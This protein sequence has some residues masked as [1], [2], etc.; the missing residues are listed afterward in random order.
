MIIQP[1][2]GGQQ[3]NKGAARQALRAGLL[4]GL[5]VL[6]PPRASAQATFSE[7]RPVETPPLHD[8]AIA[9]L[10]GDDDPD[11]VAI[12]AHP[13]NDEDADAL[14]WF[15][16]DGTGQFASAQTLLAGLPREA[17]TLKAA[18]LDGDEDPDLLIGND[19]LFDPGGLFWAANDGGAFSALVVIEPV[20]SGPFI[21]VDFDDDG[22]LDVL[23]GGLYVGLYENTGESGSSRFRRSH[24]LAPGPAGALA[25]ADFDGDGD[26]DLIASHRSFVRNNDLVFYYEQ[27]EPGPLRFSFGRVLMSFSSGADVFDRLISAI[28]MADINGDEKIDVVIGAYLRTD[29]GPEDGRV[30]W[31]K[32]RS[33]N[34]MPVFSSGGVI[35]HQ[36]RD[37]L[38]IW[39]PRVL[40]VADFDRDGDV[41]V[42]ISKSSH[43]P[44]SLAWYA[45]PGAEAGAAT[46]WSER[47]VGLSTST[48]RALQVA[49]INLDGDIDLVTREGGRERRL[50][51]Y[52]NLGSTGTAT[53]DPQHDATLVPEALKLEAVWPNPSSGAVTV[54]YQVRQ[55]GRVRLEVFDVLG[56]LV[57]TYEQHPRHAGS[58]QA[59]VTLSALAAG[60]YVLRLQAERQGVATQRIVLQ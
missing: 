9:D 28:E 16:N 10:D 47:V 23:Q 8:L 25:A 34:D 42:A 31:Y 15:E 18:D 14:V 59:E 43:G 37:V 17:R 3:A 20:E 49:D 50:A 30:R 45:N 27:Q 39:G 4:V 21:V 6:A 29:V 24:A 46:T 48:I 2:S 12:T 11:L 52:E 56:R 53:D 5:F 38:D 55:A 35:A 40:T 44:D 33:F 7:A 1:L 60:T 22:D 36:D 19:A 41:D 57:A 51:W 13:V 58:Y 54:A 26:A 32:N